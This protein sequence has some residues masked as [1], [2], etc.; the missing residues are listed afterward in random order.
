MK[1]VG[2]VFQVATFCV[3]LIVFLLAIGRWS[4][5]SSEKLRKHEEEIED[6]WNVISRRSGTRE[7]DNEAT[8]TH[9]GR[10]NRDR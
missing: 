8:E 4:G 2:L 10:R 6:I 7:R 9:P 5:S 3:S 1:D